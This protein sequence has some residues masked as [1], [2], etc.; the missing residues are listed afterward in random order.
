MAGISAGATIAP[1][2]VPELNSA[3]ASAR[4]LRGNHSATALMADGKLPPSPKP[5]ATRAL[6][7][8]ETLP[9]SACPIA[10]KL[11]AAIDTA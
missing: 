6:M 9:T 5:S 10:A 2:L 3:V 11:Q 4:S 8:P 7:K 1:T